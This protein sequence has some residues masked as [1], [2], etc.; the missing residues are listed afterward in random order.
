MKISENI[1]LDDSEIDIRAV[2]SQGSGGQHVN[3]V[4][5]AIHLRFD[6]HASSL[7]DHCKTRLLELQDRRLTGEGIIV[8]KAD[9]YRAQWQN[10]R[11]AYNRLKTLVQEA[12]VV[13]KARKPTRPTA[14]SKEKRL[15]DKA[16]RSMVK[17]MRK[18]GPCNYPP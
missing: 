10:R 12:L 7:P 1:T 13:R 11:E 5:T 15:E 14:R 6:I 3:K 8:I 17:R 4:A 18:N 2:R 9:S 16:H